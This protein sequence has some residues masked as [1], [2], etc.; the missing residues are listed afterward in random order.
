MD[1]IFLINLRKSFD[2]LW[3][4]NVYNQYFVVLGENYSILGSP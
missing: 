2:S 1:V 3:K 4:E